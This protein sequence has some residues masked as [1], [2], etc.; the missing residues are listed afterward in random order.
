MTQYLTTQPAVL[1]ATLPAGTMLQG[2]TATLELRL[3]DG[4]YYVNGCTHYY[5][6]APSQ[7]IWSSVAAP[8][9]RAEAPKLC[10]AC[11]GDES[12]REVLPG[13]LFHEEGVKAGTLICKGC[14]NLTRDTPARIR[15]RRSRLIAT[16]VAAIALDPADAFDEVCASCIEGG[17]F[18]EQ[19]CWQAGNGKWYC[20]T[21]SEE[22]RERYGL[23]NSPVDVGTGNAQ[24]SGVGEVHCFECK[25]PAALRGELC[26]Y[27]SAGTSNGYKSRQVLDAAFAEG[28]ATAHANLEA[29]KR[30]AAIEQRERPR[31][32]NPTDRR[33]FAKPHPWPE[34]DEM[35][36][37]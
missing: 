22:A 23:P 30:L 29:R 24:S 5:A 17:C 12:L 27:C 6:W 26:A 36:S 9:E 32:A 7:V 11:G 4:H 1:P 25:A 31:L 8:P 35:E 13:S 19:R 33:E 20:A 3:V 16:P 2:C 21:C 14:D 10:A 15:A 37:R 18:G 28:M 34:F